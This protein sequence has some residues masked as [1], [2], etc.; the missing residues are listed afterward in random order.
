MRFRYFDADGTEVQL[1]SVD[2]LEFRIR[3]GAVTERTLL[4][5]SAVGHWAPAG[6]HSIYRFLTEEDAPPPPE[7]PDR[8]DPSPAS[9]VPGPGDAAEPGPPDDDLPDLGFL[10]PDQGQD[11]PSPDDAPPPAP[12]R[13]PGAA[14]PRTPGPGSDGTSVRSSPSRGWGV[15]VEEVEI[16]VPLVSRS[17]PAGPEDEPD[18]GPRRGPS[19]AA[20]FATAVRWATALVLIG[21]A[22]TGLVLAWRN[23]DAEAWLRRAEIPDLMELPQVDALRAAAFGGERPEPPSGGSEA[24]ASEGGGSAVRAA[25]SPSA[26]PPAVESRAPEITAAASRDLADAMVELRRALGVS[27]SPPDPWLDGIYLANAGRFPEVGSYWRAYGN[28][29][30]AAESMEEDLFRGFVR[31]R[32]LATGFDTADAAVLS[33]RILERYRRTRP[34]REL[35]YRDLTTLADEAEALHETLVEHQAAISH[36]PFSG[37]ELSRDPVIEAVP[38]DPRLA[39]EI[40]NRLDR[41]FD[42]LERVQGVGPVSTPRLQEALFGGLTVP[43]SGS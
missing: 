8:P 35:I 33:S 5:D 34:Q 18:P 43:G 23:V 30:A 36:E 31:S 21:I 13:P 10:S 38:D 32:V 15:R 19:L 9:D 1:S 40:W 14:R 26:G 7:A 12:S 11:D 17:R 27:D 3:T 42:I 39:R 6:D 24:A 29:V 16:P 2:A 20:R 28:W 37:G 4:Y 22:S 25:A 41:I